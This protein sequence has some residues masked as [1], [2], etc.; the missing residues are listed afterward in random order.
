MIDTSTPLFPAEFLINCV[1]VYQRKDSINTGCDPKDFPTANYIASHIDAFE[2][3]SLSFS[4]LAVL[5]DCRVFV[6]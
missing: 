6:G 3:Q 5:F 1:W 4:S 2:G